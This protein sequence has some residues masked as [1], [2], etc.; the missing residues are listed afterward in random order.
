[1]PA[2]APNFRPPG[3]NFRPLG[4][5]QRGKTVHVRP[6]GC[7]LRRMRRQVVGVHG[8]AP[9]C[10]NR[11]QHG[12]AST[13]KTLWVSAHVCLF[14][15]PCFCARLPVCVRVK[16]RGAVP[17]FRCRRYAVT[18]Y[19]SG[20]FTSFFKVCIRCCIRCSMC[21]DAWAPTDPHV[22]TGAG[23]GTMT[24]GPSV[25]IQIWFFSPFGTGS[26]G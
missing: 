20:V 24:Q 13:A 25:R 8:Y 11:P 26:M 9:M 23:R 6:L 17:A 22:C 21:P 19:I 10:G 15:C 5:W 4:V 7:G 18:P 2:L 1:M 3:A 14:G 12:S 16:F